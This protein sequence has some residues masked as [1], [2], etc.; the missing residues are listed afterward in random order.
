MQFVIKTI[1]SA[2]IIAIVSTLSKKVPTLGAI[3]I[4]LPITSMLALF[5]LFSETNDIKKVISFSYSIIWIVIPSIVFFIALTIILKKNV[6][7]YTSMLFSSIIMIV[8][9]YVYIKIVRFFGIDI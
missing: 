4:S 3:I 1:I 5:W 6:N 7:F 8:S 9:Y 2:L